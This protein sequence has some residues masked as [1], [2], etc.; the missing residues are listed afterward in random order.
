M[1]QSNKRTSNKRKRRALLCNKAKKRETLGT[2]FEERP[3]KR[4]KKSSMQSS[5]EIK[6]ASQLPQ[7]KDTTS[8]P[9]RKKNTISELS[10]RNSTNLLPPSI[11]K[12]VNSQSFQKKDNQ[13]KAKGTEILS[14]TPNHKA[15]KTST[16]LDSIT[17]IPNSTLNTEDSSDDASFHTCS[18]EPQTELD[19]DISALPPHQSSV[20]SKPL[21]P[22]VKS[23]PPPSTKPEKPAPRSLP[24]LSQ[25]TPSIYSSQ[26]HSRLAAMFKGAFSKSTPS[27][28]V[29]RPSP[30]IKQPPI[31]KEPDSIIVISSSDE[32]ENEN[33]I[34]ISDSD[35]EEAI[36]MSS[37]THPAQP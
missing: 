9:P 12:N 15:P 19:M 20:K 4:M 29:E 14:K 5:Q 2:G 36:V 16:I 11:K 35:T 34:Q 31:A 17:T 23:L 32:D 21:S 28:S 7:K 6:T 22:T 8:Q 26:P 18:S 24:F 3:Q 37:R 30:L 27:T 25:H 13:L 33:V 1:N 10:Q